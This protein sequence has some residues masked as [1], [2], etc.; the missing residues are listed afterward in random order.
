MGGTKTDLRVAGTKYAPKEWVVPKRRQKEAGIESFGWV[1]LN[2]KQVANNKVGGTKCALPNV[3]NMAGGPRSVPRNGPEHLDLTRRRDPS[4]SRLAWFHEAIERLRCR[5][6]KLN[7][8]SD[9]ARCLK[10]RRTD[11]KL[12]DQSVGTKW[13]APKKCRRNVGSLGR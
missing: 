2:W 7:R 4:T 12:K 13:L 9:G 3:P 8:L 5:A 1:G 6:Q 10:V 11:S